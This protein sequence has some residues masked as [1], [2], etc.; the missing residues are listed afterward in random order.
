MSIRLL[1][2]DGAVCAASEEAMKSVDLGREAPGKQFFTSEERTNTRRE[3]AEH[4]QRQDEEEDGN[5]LTLLCLNPLLSGR[6]DS[7][8]H[9]VLSDVVSGCQSPQRV[10]GALSAARR[11][12]G[13]PVL[14]YGR[15]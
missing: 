5:Q 2:G 1:K 3:R 4:R 9:V 12:H 11:T 15:S 14:R 8:P 13:P 7:L 6:V 10:S